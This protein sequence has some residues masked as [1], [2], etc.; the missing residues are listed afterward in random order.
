M[1]NIFSDAA[2][3]GSVNESYIQSELDRVAASFTEDYNTYYAG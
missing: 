3:T 1:T 2:S